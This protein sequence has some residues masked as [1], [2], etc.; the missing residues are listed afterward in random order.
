MR[1]ST[2]RR[3]LFNPSALVLALVDRG[4]L[5]WMPDPLYLKLYFRAAM[6][7]PL[8]LRNP[9]TFNEKLQ[10]LKL[11]DRKPLY[12]RL[13]DKVAVRSYVAD[14]I[15]ESYLVPLVG[16]WKSFDEI[17][18]DALPDRFVL[19][20]NHDSGSVLPCL[21]KSTFDWDAARA[22]FTK[23]LRTN[24]YPHGREWPYKDVPPLLLAEQFMADNDSGDMT[25]YKVLCFNGTAKCVFT[26][27]NRRTGRPLTV[28]FFDTDWNRLPFE[29]HYHPDPDF[30]PKPRF[31]REMI[32]ISERFA[33]D[34]QA[35]FVRVDF[36]EIRNRLY[37]GEFTFHP[38]NGIE[39]FTPPEWDLRLGDWMDLHPDPAPS[40]A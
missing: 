6:G 22:F 31:L 23:A 37:F 9:R 16:V 12:T 32:D 33:R 34:M 18:R 13:V 27:T 40:N 14:A 28:T 7:A 5:D 11:H 24:Y 39:E 10:W 3:C 36:Y 8:H 26:C 17:D 25:D 20:T 21:D 35:I 19:K 4:A 30:I 15:G 29:R 1:W 2:L 38:G